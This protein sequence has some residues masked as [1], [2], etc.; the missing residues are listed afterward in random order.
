VNISTV[1]IPDT[2]FAHENDLL[3]SMKCIS[4]ALL[5]TDLRYT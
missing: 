3:S 5:C 4:I 1:K 2:S